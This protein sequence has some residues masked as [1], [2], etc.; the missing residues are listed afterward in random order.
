MNLAEAKALA[1]AEFL[2]FCQGITVDLA[3]LE[4]VE[5]LRI[6]SLDKCLRALEN[7]WNQN[8][9]FETVDAVRHLISF[10]LIDALLEASDI[11][12]VKMKTI[13]LDS[14]G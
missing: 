5:S 14:F 11:P 13:T 2:D 4:R 10:R 9:S 3:T 12:G 1:R 6:K 7:L 8:G